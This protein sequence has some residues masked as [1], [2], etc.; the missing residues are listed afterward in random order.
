[1]AKRVTTTSFIERAREIHGAK[2]EYHKVVYVKAKDKVEII[3]S[4]HGLFHQSPNK[5]LQG[6]GC[7]DCGKVKAGNSNK[8]SIN[9]FIE[10]ANETHQKKY[11]YSLTRYTNSQTPV[12]IE[13]KIHGVFTQ[14]PNNHLRGAGCPKC[15][16][17]RGGLKKREGS[18]RSFIFRATQVHGNRY[19]YSDVSYV[20]S[21]TPTRII[22]SKHGPFLQSPSS[23]L[24][25]RGC[26]KCQGTRLLSTAEFA[27]KAK[28]IHGEQFSYTKSHYRGSRRPVEIRCNKCN[29]YIW[30]NAGNHLAGRRCQ[31]CYGQTKRSLD[32][33]V[34]DARAVHGHRYDYTQT[35]Y[36][37]HHKK[38]LIICELHGQFTQRASGHLNGYGCP[39]CGNLDSRNKQALSREEFIE[40]AQLIHGSAYDYSSANYINQREKVDIGCSKHGTF[41]QSAGSHLAGSGCPQCAGVRT[42]EQFVDIAREKH[43]D[44]YRYPL[45]SEGQATFSMNE[46]VNIECMTH[47]IF[48]QFGSNHIK[49]HGCPKCRN[50]SE[51]R[52]SEML[53]R[54]NCKWQ[55]LVIRD[56]ARRY[57]FDFYLPDFNTLVERDGE[58]HYPKVW[59]TTGW[60]GTFIEEVGSKHTYHYQVQNDR[61][62]TALALDRGFKF[63]RIPYW[64]SDEEVETEL[65]N[66]IAGYSSYSATPDG[67]E[68]SILQKPKSLQELIDGEE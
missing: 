45:P 68:E 14:I 27:K 3:C 61:K 2:Y 63:A 17:T 12:E 8:R 47:G 40:K 33:F 19:D 67:F 28:E 11:L 5:H 41:S 58:Q 24:Q 9:E 59:A 66:I 38:L 15:A 10:K 29:R 52:I 60:F 36:R 20:D 53:N 37:G 64:L 1:M 21:G 57:H 39:E 7:P 30:Q 6:K 32:S 42:F 13:C 4:Q 48:K 49:G 26:R 46:R 31:H 56:E 43:K 25:G 65:T 34:R 22:C 62:K 44:R 18:A 54:R 35:I 51:G 55:E 16:A 50:K 23:H